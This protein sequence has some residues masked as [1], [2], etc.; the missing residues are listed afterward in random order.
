MNIDEAVTLETQ[1]SN[2]GL[3]YGAWKSQAQHLERLRKVVLAQ[4]MLV[5]IGCPVNERDMKARNSQKYKTHLEGQKEAE[6]KANKF[7]ALLETVRETI[8]NRRTIE[9]T[10][11]SEISLQR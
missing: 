5:H 10:R 4:E 1:L 3:Q 8:S 7:H 2:L 11:R 9:A 6:S